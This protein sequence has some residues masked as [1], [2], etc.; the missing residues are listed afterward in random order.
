VLTGVLAVLL[1]ATLLMGQHGATGRLGVSAVLGGTII[2]IWLRERRAG[3]A[4][5]ASLDH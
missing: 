4:L 2:G 5:A 3:L 1:L